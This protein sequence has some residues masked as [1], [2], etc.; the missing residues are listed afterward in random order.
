MRK[1]R[2][3]IHSHVACLFILSVALAAGLR[4]DD[5]LHKVWA[6]KDCRIVTPGG[7]VLEKAVIVIRDGLD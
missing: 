1:P 6:V 5:A 2:H 3:D 7:P 4:A